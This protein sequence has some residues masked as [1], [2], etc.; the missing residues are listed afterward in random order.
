MLTVICDAA[1]LEHKTG[2]FHPESPN[3]IAAIKEA[4]DGMA[5][6]DQIRWQIPTSMS[7]GSLLS[8]IEGVHDATY[9]RSLQQLCAQGGGHVDGDTPVS[10]SSYAVALLA[11]NAW[12]DGVDRAREGS[13]CFVVARPPGHHALH[14]RGMGFCLLNNAA[15]AAHYA[16][17]QGCERVAIL[18][19]DVHHGN[20]TQAL[21]EHHPQIAYCSLHEFPHYPGTGGASDTDTF[22]GAFNNVLNIPMNAGSD[23]RDY[24]RAFESQVMPFLRSVAPELVIVSAGYDAAAADPLSNINLMP[25]D[26]GRMTRSVLSLTRSIVFGLE[27]GYDLDALGASVVATIEAC[28]ENVHDLDILN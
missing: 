4:I 16:L 14:D 21:V 8:W 9:L 12:M 22:N 11:V 1:F 23:G 6:R 26:Y 10:A 25:M 13:P 3:R 5:L 28:L 2:A 17:A 27:G 20:G 18:D 19:W 7:V 15:I 24:D